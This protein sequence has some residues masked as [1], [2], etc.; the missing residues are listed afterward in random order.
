MPLANA[1]TGALAT[2]AFGTSAFTATYRELGE[3]KNTRQA[4]DITGIADTGADKSMPGDGYK[5]GDI[6]IEFFW[7]ATDVPLDIEDV[8]ETITLTLPKSVPASAAAATVIGTGF[9]L[10]VTLHPKLSRN[11][12]NMGTAKIHWDGLTGPAYTKEA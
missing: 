5:A 2:I 3:G 12:V 11:N 9:L 10:E 6:D 7:D 4:L 8:P 1:D